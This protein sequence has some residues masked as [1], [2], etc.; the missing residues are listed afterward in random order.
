MRRDPDA[1][2]LE[3]DRNLEFGVMQAVAP[4]GVPVPEMYWLEEDAGWIER[5]FCMMERIDGCESSPNKVLME[6]AMFAVR[7][8]VGAEF[9]SIL[10]RIHRIDTSLASLGFL[11]PAPA[12]EECAIREVERW[13]A[14]IRQEALEPQ[15]VLRGALRWMR[16]NLPRPPEQLVIVH[17][18]YRTG[19]YLADTTGKIRGI[20]DWEM[21]HLGDPMEDVAWASI[22]PWRWLGN[23]LVGGLMERGE[24]FRRYEEESGI[25]VDEEAIRFWEVLGNVKLAAIFLTGARSFCEG[26]TRSA[27]MAFIGRNVRRLELEVMDLMRV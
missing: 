12:P 25:K 27:M 4:E 1:S 3:S 23:E 17:A 15:P 24:F 14:I 20:L 18:D 8:Q 13:D 21:T 10:A 9:T 22:R 2:L 11:G 16:H 26:R 7:E 19:N 5:P 6:P